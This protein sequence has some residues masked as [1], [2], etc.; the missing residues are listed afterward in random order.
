MTGQLNRAEAIDEILRVF[1]PRNGDVAAAERHLHDLDDAELERRM[2]I[3]REGE[4][5]V[6]E[7]SADRPKP[8]E[9]AARTQRAKDERTSDKFK[10]GLAKM[11]EAQ[12]MWER[13]LKGEPL[14][15]AAA[16]ESVR[17]TSTV[18][19]KTRTPRSTAR[20]EDV[21]VQTSSALGWELMPALELE[22]VAQPETARPVRLADRD[23]LTG[24]E[25]ASRRKGLTFSANKHRVL[26]VQNVI[27]DAV[28]EDVL[29]SHVV[30]EG[31]DP[32]E[33]D[34]ELNSLRSDLEENPVL[35]SLIALSYRHLVFDT[36]KEA[37]RTMLASQAERSARRWGGK[38]MGFDAVTMTMDR[39]ILG[40]FVQRLQIPSSI[41]E[42][43]ILTDT[44]RI[45]SEQTT[46]ESFA[47]LALV[48]ERYSPDLVVVVEDDGG[49]NTGRLL[50][51]IVKFRDVKFGLNTLEK[52][53]RSRRAQEI[54]KILIVDDMS[55]TGRTMG[56]Y[57]SLC[58]KLFPNRSVGGMAL[59]GS[60]ASEKALGEKVY[61]PAVSP[62]DQGRPPWKTTG[63]FKRVGEAF[64]LGVVESAPGF[65]VQRQTLERS[66][67]R[68]EEIAFGSHPGGGARSGSGF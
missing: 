39:P 9:E 49:A 59:V 18:A 47:K 58:E 44:P 7:Q 29:R 35:A 16:P 54:E 1:P 61:F 46:I 31:V 5:F 28:I 48:A 65:E 43:I 53:S 19:K 37:Q 57:I 41:S 22:P 13:H 4:A 11:A 27:F 20:V 62:D 67:T 40:S 10:L 52:I 51:D 32:R 60:F 23:G 30:E 55:M 2:E 6:R 17:T 66:L 42:P 33:V 63:V 56:R 34:L 64:E 25:A 12:A 8:S 36:L 15:P 50:Q 26:A 68:F 38:R 3:I 21:V 45:P 24:R 14:E